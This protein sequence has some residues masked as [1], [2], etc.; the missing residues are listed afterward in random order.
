MAPKL[1]GPHRMVIVRDRGTARLIGSL[2]QVS[3]KL[4]LTCSA[5]ID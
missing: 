5:S 1:L 2:M 4:R 3:F